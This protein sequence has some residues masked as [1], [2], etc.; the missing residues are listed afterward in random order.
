MAFLSLQGIKQPRSGCAKVISAQRRATGALTRHRFALG[1]FFFVVVVVLIPS[2][3]LSLVEI[4]RLC[5]WEGRCAFP[6]NMQDIRV[7]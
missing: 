1:L 5:T 7:S 4:T 6:S 2:G 3:V